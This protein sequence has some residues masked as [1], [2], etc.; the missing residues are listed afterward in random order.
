MRVTKFLTAVLFVSQLMACG[1]GGG[2]PGSSGSGT[3][4]SAQAG[5]IA[6]K[7]VSGGSDSTTATYSITASEKTARAKVLLTDR[8][9]SPVANSIVTFEESGVSLLKFSPESKTALTNK[10]GEAEI[11]VE[12]L[13]TTSIGATTVVATAILEKGEAKGS[14]NLAVTSA[15]VI[16]VDPQTVASA[17]NFVSVDPSDKSIVI[18]GSGGNSRSESAILKFKVVD[19]NGDP[20]KDVLVNFSVVPSDAVKLNI[21]SAK[22]NNDGVV[23]TSVSSKSTPTAVI[24]RASV[25]GRD[26]FSQSDQLTVTT[27]VAVARGFDLSASKFNLNTDL[28]GDNSTIRIGVIDANGNPVSDGVPVIST[29]DFGRVGTSGRGG[30]TTSNGICNVEY[31]IQNPRPADGQLINVTVSTQVGSGLQISDSIQL[32]AT[33]VSWLDLY[34]DMQTDIITHLSPVSWDAKC[35]ATVTGFIGTNNRFPAP[36]GTTIELKPVSDIVTATVRSGSP[37]LDKAFSRTRVA[38]QFE[39]QDAVAAGSTQIELKFTAGN[40]VSSV[41]KTISYPACDPV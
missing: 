21:S 26:I 17:L 20:V 8:S 28:S 37:T 1:G 36:A 11:D 10:N 34:N 12:A 19:K 32:T 6:L 2:D 40:S 15:V 41:F 13:S 7:I 31:Q 33:S 27:G 4:G 3:D 38:F 9:G 30:C 22:S 18:A 35:K 39:L 25:N 14:Q 23:T 24:I 16:G 5:V 29:S